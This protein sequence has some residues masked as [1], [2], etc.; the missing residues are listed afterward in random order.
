MS[1]EKK[2][3]LCPLC[4][5]FIYPR[6]L[7]PVIVESYRKPVAGKEVEFELMQR[8]MGHVV[9]V[10]RAQFHNLNL[11]RP[12]DAEVGEPRL[13]HVSRLMLTFVFQDG[14]RQFLK[15]RPITLAAECITILLRER[16]D[17]LSDE[18]EQDD[19]YVIKA[20]AAL[21]A[22]WNAITGESLTDVGAM[23]PDVTTSLPS[24]AS[25][26][27][28]SAVCQS[29]SLP[30][31]LAALSISPVS[32]SS[33]VASAMSPPSSHAAN[34][35]ILFFQQKHSHMSFLHP[36]C[37]TILR[38]AFGSLS[39]APQTLSSSVIEVE[40]MVTSPD[41]RRKYPMFS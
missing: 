6:D 5:D 15:F 2:Y 41:L 3:A 29:D 32:S 11:D 1:E 13:S 37:M 9:A 17:L 30:V 31:P 7:R 27:V 20:K 26:A 24:S 22:R 36:V 14:L 23:H 40:R 35:P 28:P 34:D 21:C 8:E 16:D 19:Q 38:E 12:F 33:P 10:P 18:C 25:S 4:E 39:Q